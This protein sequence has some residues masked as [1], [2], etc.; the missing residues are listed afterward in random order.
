MSKEKPE[1]GDVW[2]SPFGTYR[3]VS[4]LGNPFFRCLIWDGKENIDAR[5][6]R[7]TFLLKCSYCGKSKHDTEHLF[8]VKNEL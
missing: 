4:K 6:V 8:E 5:T 2:K 7:L 3:V 1:V